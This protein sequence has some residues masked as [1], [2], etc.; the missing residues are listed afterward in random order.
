[1]PMVQLILWLVFKDIRH[2]MFSCTRAMEVWK[3]LV[4]H[5]MILA[6]TGR[7]GSVVLEEIL[8]RDWKK[9]IFIGQYGLKETIGVGAWY[10]W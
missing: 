5:E 9:Q 6:C 8:R 7:L 1:M 10:I 4:L 2:L 3:S